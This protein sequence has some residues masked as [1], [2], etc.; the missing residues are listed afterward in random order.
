MGARSTVTI[1]IAALA[2]AVQGV[3]AQQPPALPGAFSGLVISS[4]DSQPVPIAEVRLMRVDSTRAARN[5]RAGAPLEIFI[6]SSRTRLTTT[7]SVGAFL[8][9]QLVPG[10]YM[11][12]VRRMGYAPVEGVVAIDSTS[13]LSVI[14]MPETSHALAT[15]KVTERA[16]DNLDKVLARSGYLSRSHMGMRA[17]FVDRQHIIDRREYTVRD[18]LAHYGLYDANIL[19]D[20]MPI[21]YQDIENFSAENVA[22][23]EIYQHGRP[24]EFAFYPQ[25]PGAHPRLSSANHPVFPLVVI[26]TFFP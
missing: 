21:T 9:R 7:D 3:S 4:R 1:V 18:I 23:I 26:W 10:R 19:F 6:D 2:C 12:R 17:E 24:V 11:L 25:V 5:A 16:Y 8:I 15:V 22:A 14:P 20:R 13:L